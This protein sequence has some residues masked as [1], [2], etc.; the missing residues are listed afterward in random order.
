MSTRRESVVA[1]TLEATVDV[2]TSAVTT[3][4]LD[5]QTLIVVHAPSSGLIQHISRRA[6]ASERAICV[7]ALAS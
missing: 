4:V 5:S 3:D 7:D 2:T 6:L 1:R